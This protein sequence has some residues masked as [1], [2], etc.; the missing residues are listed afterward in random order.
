M[1]LGGEMRVSGTALSTV[2]AASILVFFARPAAHAQSICADLRGTYYDCQITSRYSG[3]VGFELS[4]YSRMGFIIYVV[5]IAHEGRQL[6]FPLL[7]DGVSRDVLTDQ[8]EQLFPVPITYLATCDQQNLVLAV[9]VKGLF[10]AKTEKFF[11]SRN[12]ELGLNIINQNISFGRV[13]QENRYQ[14][15]K[16]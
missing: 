16:R 9:S 12:G 15:P 2:F 1:S 10:G 5:K 13:T 7:C 14:C 3:R 4:Q 6:Q 11:I 8:N